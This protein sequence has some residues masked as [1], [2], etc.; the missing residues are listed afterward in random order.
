MMNIAKNSLEMKRKV[1]EDLT[2]RNLYPYTK[3]YLGDI[4]KRS[5]GYWTNHFSTIGILGMNEAVINLKHVPYHTEEGRNFAI[6]VLDFMLQYLE[7]F[8]EETGHLYN[9]EASPAEGASYRLAKAD[10]SRYPDIITSG[11]EEAPYYTNSVHLPVNYTDDIFELLDHQDPLQARFTGGTVIH[12]FLGEKI[13]DPFIVAKLVQK[14]A[15]SY[16]LPYYSITP[17]FSICPVHGYIPG[18]HWV[19]PYPHTEAE[20]KRYGKYR[21]ALLS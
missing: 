21:E 3:I 13:T 1:V 11:T 7:T 16:H 15:H 2:E 18:E 4:K 8:K 20:L 10:K 19:C 14:I 5:G 6:R 9:L 17:T 12:V